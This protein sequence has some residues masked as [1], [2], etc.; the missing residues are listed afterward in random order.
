MGFMGDIDILGLIMTTINIIKTVASAMFKIVKAVFNAVFG[1]NPQEEA[2]KATFEA[3]N[4][5]AN[6]QLAGADPQGVFFGRRGNQYVIKREDMD[7]HVLVVGI[8]ASGKSS[9]VAIP[10]LRHWKGAVFAVDIKGE[11]SANTKNHRR[12]VKVFEPQN[13][14]SPYIYDPYIFLNASNNPAQEAQ[15]I[16]QAIIPL[17]HDVKEPFWIESAQI[18]LTGAI[19]H[20]HH[21]K[22]SFIST[23][24]KVQSQNPQ[25]LVEVVAGS[26]C[27][28]AKLCAKGFTKMEGKLLAGIYAEISRGI[29]ALVTDDEIVSALTHEKSKEIISPKDLE[30]GTDVYIKIPEHLLRQWKHLLTLIVNQFISFFERRAESPNNHPILFLLDEFPRLGKIPSITD[31]LATLRSKKITICIII[32]SLAQLKMIYGHDTQEVIAD[33]CAFKAIL[34]ATDANTQEYF[35][36]LV[37]TYEKFRTSKSQNY[38]QYIGAPTGSGINTSQDYEKRIIKPEEFATLQKELILL[39]PMPLNFCRVQKQPYYAER[40]S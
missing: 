13:E 36:K 4:P 31:A 34:G 11:L 16:A 38:D 28:K 29:I 7:G 18:L 23:L 1:K 6:G 22:E 17:S 5:P 20:Y 21:L 39:Y 15:A 33:T 32:Q 19:L 30:N 10:T 3:R 37:G 40:N 9:C 2:D 35:S 27:D 8:P 14:E 12:N 24:L 25:T 26:P